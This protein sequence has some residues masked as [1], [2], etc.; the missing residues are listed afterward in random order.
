MDA[1]LSH[2]NEEI[3]K[4]GTFTKSL[5]EETALINAAVT[6][7]NKKSMN[8]IPM[9]IV[10]PKYQRSSYDERQLPAIAFVNQDNAWYDKQKIDG[11]STPSKKINLPEMGDKMVKSSKPCHMISA[12][13]AMK[14]ENA[15]IPTDIPPSTN[16]LQTKMAKKK[17]NTSVAV[18]QPRKKEKMDERELMQIILQMQMKK[19]AARLNRNQSNANQIHGKSPT[20][21]TKAIAQENNKNTIRKMRKQQKDESGEN[22]Y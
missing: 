2:A 17:N 19:N 4:I 8:Q 10:K 16:A 12:N 9:A 6:K 14:T 7:D 13:N 15:P 18:V 5:A 21:N 20:D 11:D 3:Y 22:C 1:T